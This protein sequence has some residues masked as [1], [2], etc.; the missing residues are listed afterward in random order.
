MDE[1]RIQLGPMDDGRCPSDPG[2]RPSDGAASSGVSTVPASIPNAAYLPEVC[3]WCDAPKTT[4]AA[5]CADCGRFGE[6]RPAMPDPAV[7]EQAIRALPAE[8]A[9]W[10]I[11]G[12]G[13]EQLPDAVIDNHEAGYCNAMACA[14]GWSFMLTR[15]GEALASGIEARSHETP[16]AAQPVGQEPGAG[17]ADAQ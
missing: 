5:L 9:R 13:F 3:G 14:G 6:V 7:L 16:K 17:T 11:N 15:F 4:S 2:S 1:E 8:R 10:L 12:R